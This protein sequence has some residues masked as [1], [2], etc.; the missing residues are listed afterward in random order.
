MFGPRE[1]T[2]LELLIQE[3]IGKAVPVGS[4]TLN[5]KYLRQLSPATIRNVLADLEQL[6]FLTQ[7]HASAGRVPTEKGFRFYI[8]ALV[9]FAELKAA[10]KQEIRHSL[11]QEKKA[12]LEDVLRPVSQALSALTHHVTLI[13][14]PPIEATAF[15]QINFI[16]L[17]EKTVLAVL[18]GSDQLVQN[19]LVELEEDVA[20]AELDQMGRYLAEK[21]AGLS[22][23]GVREKILA[24]MREE[25]VQY[26]RLL[27][28]ALQLALA[29]LREEEESEL[30]IEGEAHL[31]D[32]AQVEDLEQLRQIYRAFERK[33]Q[34][35]KLLD[36]ALQAQ[37]LKIFIGSEILEG[38]PL[39]VGLVASTYR[40]GGRPIGTLGVIG[41]LRMDYSRIIPLVEF[42]AETISNFLAER[43]GEE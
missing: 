7:P 26:D 9:R 12:E 39:Q 1:K 40:R 32:T 6:G 10:E 13:L 22:I 16:R 33:G 27:K 21:L 17:R 14:A 3:Y 8:D 41:P 20:Q 35:V 18:V 36:R 31:F 38:E 15:R 29:A 4:Q 2:I 5:R 43:E 30:L 19:R 34:L 28:R 37:G 25:K 23:A 24:E 11:Q 42:T